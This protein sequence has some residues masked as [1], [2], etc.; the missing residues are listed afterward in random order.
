MQ[1]HDRVVRLGQRHVRGE[2]AELAAGAPFAT[3]T[4]I[5]RAPFTRGARTVV[6]LRN[7]SFDTTT[8]ALTIERGDT[9]TWF[10]MESVSMSRGRWVG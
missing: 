3:G 5:S 8:T 7:G 10:R 9:M 2:D 4:W 1:T 6:D